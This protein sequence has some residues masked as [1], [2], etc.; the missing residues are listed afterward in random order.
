MTSD[1]HDEGTMTE[2]LHMGAASVSQ[3]SAFTNVESNH[4]TA[5]SSERKDGQA[6]RRGGSVQLP[7]NIDGDLRT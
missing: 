4:N 5:E 2:Y 1:F 3:L 6:Y 7:S